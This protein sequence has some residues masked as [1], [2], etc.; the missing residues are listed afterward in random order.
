MLVKDIGAFIKRRRKDLKITQPYLAELAG[1]SVNTLYKI[2]RGE[3]NPTLD[4]IERIT[5]VLGL[6]VKLTVK[7]LKPRTG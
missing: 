2:E 7:K 4:V 6:E 5:D 1:V 3:G